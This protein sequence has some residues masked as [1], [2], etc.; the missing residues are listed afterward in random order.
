M[1]KRGASEITLYNFQK[2]LFIVISNAPLTPDFF[3]AKQKYHIRFY[4]LQKVEWLHNLDNLLL[5]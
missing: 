5:I 3:L 4:D 1:Q 2:T